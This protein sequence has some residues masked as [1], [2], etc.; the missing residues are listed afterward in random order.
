M[1]PGAIL[2]LVLLFSGVW[3]GASLGLGGIVQLFSIG[4]LVQ[5]RAVGNLLYNSTDNFLLVAV[6]LF[7]FMG[8][9]FQRSGLSIRFYE[10]AAKLFGRFPGGLLQTNI[11]GCAIFSAVAGSSAAVAATMST[12]AIPTMERQGYD[13]ELTYG[14]LAAGGTLGILIPPSLALIIYGAMVLQPVPEL[15]MAGVM[16]GLM[17]AGIFSLYLA[18]RV[19]LK[20][21]LAPLPPMITWRERVSSLPGL[22]PVILLVFILLGGIYTGIATPTEVAAL[23]SLACI[24]L[25]IAY[26]CFS[27]AALRDS[28]LAATRT[29]CMVMF[30]VLGALTVTFAVSL[31][32][33]ERQIFAAVGAYHGPSLVVLIL[34]LLMYGILGMFLD[35]L[36]MMLLSLPV[37]YPVIIALGYD[38]IWFAV[39]LVIWIEIGL[40]TPPVGINLFIVRGI[41]RGA[42]LGEVIRGAT[43]FVFLMILGT[44][45][46]I[47]FPSI[48]LWLPGQMK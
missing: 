3:I 22:I 13:K 24:V 39:I 6:P 35:G 36:S 4:G 38:P 33:V 21:G 11:I 30:I 27:W 26:R 45:L 19:L 41:A 28:L 37:V 18:I 1:I 43:P 15:F 7:I 25:A 40:L 29:T 47:A 42:T 17:L 8:E 23:G 10:S 44:V 48:A 16:P 31:S 14:S 5:M 46:L 9:A 12:V 32:G 20:P 34:I 2:L